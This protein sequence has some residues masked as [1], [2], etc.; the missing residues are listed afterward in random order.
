[1]IWTLLL[2]CLFLSQL[3]L[4][5]PWVKIWSDPWVEPCC[6]NF[7]LCPTCFQSYS[8]G[9][10]WRC[11]V[12]FFV[13]YTESWRKNLDMVQWIPPMSMYLK[14]LLCGIICEVQ[15]LYFTQREMYIKQFCCLQVVTVS[16]SSLTSDVG[17]D[18]IHPPLPLSP[19]ILLLGTTQ[20]HYPAASMLCV[21]PSLIV[22]FI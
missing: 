8:D 4:T 13:C 3:V 21:W 20:L 18:P 17:C 9:S 16:S 14:H 6:Q 2:S 22:S 19:L 11:R 10:P 12:C 7:S 1:M 5:A 15:Q